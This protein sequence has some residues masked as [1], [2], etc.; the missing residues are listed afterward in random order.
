MAKRTLTILCNPFPVGW[1][2]KNLLWCF[3]I[4]ATMGS[5]IW[6][7]DDPCFNWEMI[8]L[9]SWRVAIK[10]VNSSLLSS[11]L[12]FSS[13]LSSVKTWILSRLRCYWSALS[14]ACFYLSV[15]SSSSSGTYLSSSTFCSVAFVKA[16]L[17]SEILI[18]QMAW[19]FLLLASCSLCSATKSDLMALKRPRI[20]SAEPPCSSYN[21]TTSRMVFP[22]VLAFKEERKLSSVEVA[23]PNT[24]SVATSKIAFI[25]IILIKTIPKTG[26][27][28]IINS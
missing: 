3:W 7:K 8:L 25:I 23:N 22:K 9:A 15:Y 5:V 27:F 14:S 24:Q 19:S 10:A 26:S 18:S 21:W 1:F 16:L 6:R 4:S 11:K 17:A 12:D 2:F 20:L 28:Q 13:C